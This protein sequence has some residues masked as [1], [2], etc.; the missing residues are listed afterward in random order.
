MNNSEKE[1]QK[2][3]LY[4]VGQ[5]IDSPKRKNVRIYKV[6][7]CE[8]IQKWCYDYDYGLGNTSEGFFYSSY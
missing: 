5:I 1:K 8:D 7:W 3:H 6:T 4:S 2:K